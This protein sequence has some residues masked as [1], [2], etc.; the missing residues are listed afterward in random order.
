L[1]AA[2]ILP[3]VAYGS[4]HVVDGLAIAFKG[5]LERLGVQEFDGVP[6]GFLPVSREFFVAFPVI[7]GGV[8]VDA[9]GTS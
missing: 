8:R 5:S 4:P 3:D 6:L 7:I 9:S 1:Q 2:V